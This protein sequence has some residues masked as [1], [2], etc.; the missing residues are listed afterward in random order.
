MQPPVRFQFTFFRPR[1][2]FCGA[3]MRVRCRVKVASAVVFY[4]LGNTGMMA[5]DLRGYLPRGYPYCQAVGNRFPFLQGKRFASADDSL[6][7]LVVALEY[8]IDVAMTV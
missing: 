1:P 5:A 4:L 8:Q 3:F 6:A 7:S 2:Q